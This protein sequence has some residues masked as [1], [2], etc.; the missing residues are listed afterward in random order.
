[1]HRIDTPDA[2]NGKFSDGN[3]AEG[4]LATYPDADWCNAVQEEPLA[5]ILAAGLT[6]SK[7]DRTQLLQAIRALVGNGSPVQRGFLMAPNT[8]NPTTHVDIGAGV[9]VAHSVVDGAL[10]QDYSEYLTVPAMT[11]RVDQVFAAGTGK[12][13]RA[14]PVSLATDQTL[15]VFAVK[16]SNN[17]V[18]YVA[19]TS[20]SAANIISAY[21]PKKVA[22]LG[23]LLTEHAN[24]N[25]VQFDQF[26]PMTARVTQFREQRVEYSAAPTT[27]ATETVMS[28]IPKGIA[29]SVVMD[30]GW[31]G[32]IAVGG[33]QGIRFSGMAQTDQ[34]PGDGLEQIIV[35]WENQVGELDVGSAQV[36]LISDASGKIRHRARLTTGVLYISVARIIDA[37]GV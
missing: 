1:M 19:D 10:V 26:G 32:E 9:I 17:G 12:G 15:H 8:S 24:T 36:S 4:Q 33:H 6:P 35:A 31:H 21:A 3:P 28:R 22:R 16:L 5:V 2:V 7:S 25:L 14:S 34:A 23:W 11:K 30:A 13:M 27:T 20:A 37:V 29:T 18:D